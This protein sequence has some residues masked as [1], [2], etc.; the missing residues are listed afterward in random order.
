MKPRPVTPHS[1]YGEPP[2]D[3]WMAVT[4]T[5]A[6]DGKIWSRRTV[7]LYCGLFW[8]QEEICHPIS[9]EAIEADLADRATGR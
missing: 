1:Q 7:T 2:A 9:R 8:V 5:F 3:G 4:E 6:A